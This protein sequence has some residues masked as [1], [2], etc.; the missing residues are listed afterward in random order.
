MVRKKPIPFPPEPL[1]FIFIRL[2]Q[3]SLMRADETGKRNIWLKLLDRF[4]LG[5]DS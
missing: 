4:G 5:F 2:T 3:W 1:R